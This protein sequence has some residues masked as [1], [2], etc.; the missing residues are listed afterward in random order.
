[1]FWAPQ[2]PHIRGDDDIGSPGNPRNRKREEIWNGSAEQPLQDYKDYICFNAVVS[3]V[4]MHQI[5]FAWP[6]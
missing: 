4:L 5:H 1:M 6:G 3:F 2:C